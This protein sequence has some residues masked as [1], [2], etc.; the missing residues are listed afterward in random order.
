[1]NGFPVH[2]A[3]DI[4]FSEQKTK[5]IE[6]T[7]DAN[8]KKLTKNLIVAALFGGVIIASDSVI[9]AP[10]FI[11][12]DLYF[13]FQNQTGGGSADYIINLGPTNGIVGGSS[14][15]N[16]SGFSISTFKAASLQGINASSIWG[17]V[18][19]GNSSDNP[20]FIW[21]T[22]LRSGGPGAPSV[23]GSSAPAATGSFADDAAI[24]DL[25]ELNCPAV[26]SGVLD[27]SKTW[28]NYVE[29]SFSYGT[30][31]G[32][33]GINP[34]SSFDYTNT[35]LY[36][37]LY[38]S[39]T[40]GSAHPYVYQGYFTLNLTGG[41]AVFTFTPKNAPAPLTQPV[42]QSITVST[43]SATVVWTAVPTHTYQLQYDTDLNF[44]NWV[45][46]GTAKLASLSLMTNTDT[47]A[48]QSSKF[49]RVTGQ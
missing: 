30:F 12:N 47:S 29:P 17:G 44:S 49:Y 20:S 35:V 13:G 32:D 46:V 48:T 11:P 1:M 45:N 10:T 38:V 42:I 34:D 25:S 26:G 31:Y 24:A 18:V 39:G 6:V 7:T 3:A 5:N 37:D 33:S 27:T 43:N 2:S 36:E 21:A 41:S 19:G 23:P 4:V 28:E 16:L 8:M 40:T 15:V 9:G 14:V 22:Q